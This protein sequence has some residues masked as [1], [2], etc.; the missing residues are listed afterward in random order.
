MQAGRLSVTELRLVYARQSGRRLTLDA[1]DGVTRRRL[2]FEFDTKRETD[3][4]FLRSANW[5]TAQTELAYVRGS[6][7]SALIEIGE[8]LARASLPS[9]EHLD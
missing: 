4:H 2:T 5:I 6:R 7:E 8:L 1:H 9:E 3:A